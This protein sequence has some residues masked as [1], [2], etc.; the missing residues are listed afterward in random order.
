MIKPEI[1]GML[2]E[3]FFG[4]SFFNLKLITAFTGIHPKKIPSAILTDGM[5][6]QLVSVQSKGKFPAQH[7]W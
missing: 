5:N 6:K 7:N 3:I 1:G 4:R 2:P